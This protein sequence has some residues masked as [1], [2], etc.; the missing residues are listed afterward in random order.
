VHDLFN[1]LG[2]DF[3]AFQERRFVDAQGW[4][5][6]DGLPAGVDDQQATAH[7]FLTNIAAQLG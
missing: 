4:G 6:L 5:Q 2:Q 1:R 3:E 7:G